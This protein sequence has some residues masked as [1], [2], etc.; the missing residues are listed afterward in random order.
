MLEWTLP[1]TLVHLGILAILI[2][3]N[4][5]TALYP[6]LTSPLFSNRAQ[7]YIGKI[8][9]SAL[10]VSVSKWTDSILDSWVEHITWIWANQTL[11]PWD[12]NLEQIKW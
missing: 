3:V 10:S 1:D 2:I 12:L 11:F 8:A 4:C 6:A 5:A 9:V 7:F